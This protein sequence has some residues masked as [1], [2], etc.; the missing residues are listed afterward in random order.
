MSRAI[1]R[2]GGAPTPPA[3]GGGIRQPFG[4]RTPRQT[5][6]ARAPVQKRSLR[7]RPPGWAVEIFSEL[8]KVTWPTRDETLYLTMVVILVSVAVGVLLGSIDVFF[9]WLIDRVLLQ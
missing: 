1:R 2:R 4:P 9:N 7:P 6:G 3:T 8:K 5:R